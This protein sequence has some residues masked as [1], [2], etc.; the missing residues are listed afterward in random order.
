[1]RYSIE[2]DPDNT[3]RAQIREANMS[4]KHAVE[5]CK[6]IRGLELQN[7]KDQLG[8]VI[9]LKRAVP[10]KRYK[11]CVAHR[12]GEGFGPGRYPTRAARIILKLL[13]DC[14]SNAEYGGLNTDVLF[15]KHIVSHR[16]RV[17]HGW[18]PRAHGR[19]TDWDIHTVNMELILEEREE[20]DGQ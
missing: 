7:A 3:A 13:E 14:E 18:M 9:E 15:I 5:I 12:K 11:R 6:M 10:F 16:G 19:S 20:E 2:V 4:P 17:I 1:M 8:E